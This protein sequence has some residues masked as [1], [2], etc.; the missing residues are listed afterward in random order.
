MK[1]KKYAFAAAVSGV[2]L[3]GAI[4]FL[5]Q[6]GTSFFKPKPTVHVAATIFPLYDL[7]KGIGGDFVTTDLLLPTGNPPE[8]AKNI[9]QNIDSASYDAVFAIGQGFDETA[10]S[11]DLK[12]NIVTVDHGIDLLLQEGSTASPYYWL[13]LKNSAIMAATIADRLGTLDPSHR[14]QFKK[15]AAGFIDRAGQLDQSIKKLIAAAPQKKMVVYGRDWEYFARDYGI[16]IVYALPVTSEP[17]TAAAIGELLAAARA[18]DIH[19]LVADVY[20]TPAPLLAF[21]QTGRYSIINLDALGGSS[22]LTD[23]L[24]LMNYNAQSIVTALTS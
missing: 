17:P 23:Y 11:A 14:E 9:L 12:P 13:S 8:A 18:N 15:N 16:T 6:Q 10:A 1:S 19:A 3:M 24:I 2:V 7:V 22:D 5:Q 21:L 4:L 20:V